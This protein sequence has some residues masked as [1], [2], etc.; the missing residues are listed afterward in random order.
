MH[1]VPA[2]VVQ[3]TQVPHVHS[4]NESDE[5][6]CSK[7]KGG[8]KKRKTTRDHIFQHMQDM[9]SSFQHEQTQNR[10]QRERHQAEKMSIM[11]NLIEKLKRNRKG[12]L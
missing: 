5:E 11:A 6:K 4:S 10:L 8:Q 3:S 12:D 7:V 2:V 1:I 9:A